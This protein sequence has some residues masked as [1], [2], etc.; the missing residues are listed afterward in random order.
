LPDDPLAALGSLERRYDGPIP[1][2]LRLV[3]RQGSA[4]IVRRLHADAQA[5]FFAGM[6]KRQA[7][8]IRQRRADASFYAAMI[9]DLAYYRRER[10]R[11]RETARLLV[12]QIDAENPPSTVST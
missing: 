9:A 2:N 5:R 4:T 8:A 7:Q 1:E 12:V 3:A 11:W 10:R 6:V